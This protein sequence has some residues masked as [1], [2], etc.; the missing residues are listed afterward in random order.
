MAARVGRGAG[1]PGPEACRRLACDRAVTRVLASRH[2]QPPGPPHDL[3]EE[4]GS[5]A[6][7]R[8]AMALLPP[9]WVE[10]RASRW[11]GAGPPGSSPGHRG[12]LAIRDGGCVFPTASGRWPGVRPSPVAPA[13]RRPHRP[14]QPGLAGPR[15]SSGGPRGRP[16]AD[17]PTRRPPDRHPSPATPP[18][19]SP[20][21][22]AT[23]H[24]RLT[25]GSIPTARSPASLVPGAPTSRCAHQRNPGAVDRQSD[26]RVGS[27]TWGRA[28]VSSRW[29]FRADGALAR[30]A[31]SDRQPGRPAPARV[32]K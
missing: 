1:P 20:P 9:S 5:A 30:A 13:G 29:G 27:R 2:P 23:P 7:L 26:R 11:T 10:P 25:A 19:T 4:D 21:S 3:S 17:P 32:L 24:R 15:A 16:A 18:T 28:W 22:P 31:A 6:R 8:S 14:G 12:A